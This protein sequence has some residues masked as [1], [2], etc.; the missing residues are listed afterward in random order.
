MDTCTSTYQVYDIINPWNIKTTC[1][2][3]FPVTQVESSQSG[4]TREETMV[5]V[6]SPLTTTTEG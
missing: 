3:F 5:D 1:D 2:V 4:E 6:P